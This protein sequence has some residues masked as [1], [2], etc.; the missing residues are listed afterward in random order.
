MD[1][2]KSLRKI[3]LTEEDFKLLLDIKQSIETLLDK[4]NYVLSRHTLRD[5]GWKGQIIP[6]E[7]RKLF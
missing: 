6:F 7:K 2:E 1:Q 4:F 3:E 5:P